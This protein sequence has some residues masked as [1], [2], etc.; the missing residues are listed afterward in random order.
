MWYLKLGSLFSGSGTWE[1]AASLCKINPV[2]S[3]EIEPFPIKVTNARFPNT[4]QLGDIT[5]INGAEIEPVDIITFSSPCQDLSIAGNRSGL[6]GEQS[7]LFME[8]IRIIREMRLATNNEY[9][10]FIIWENV[11]G[12]F[13]SNKGYDFRT[14]LEEIAETNIPIPKYGKWAN[15]GM[16]ELSNCQ[17]AWRVLDAQHWGVPQRRKRI[18]LI[19][20]FGGKCAREI[21]FK[22]EGLFGDIEKSGEKEKGTSKDIERSIRKTSGVGING[23]IAGTL[24]AKITYNISSTLNCMHEQ[25]YIATY[26]TNVIGL[27]RRAQSSTGYISKTLSASVGG[28]NIPCITYDARGNGDG[29]ICNTITGDHEN[30]ITDYT[31]LVIDNNITIPIHDKATRYK[32]GEKTRN[33]DGSANGLGIGQN[34]D[35]CPTLDT[36]GRHAIFSVNKSFENSQ[37]GNYREGIGTLRASGGDYGGGSENQIFTSTNKDN[38]Y[39]VRRLTPKECGRLQGFPDSWCDDIPHSD[40]AE[41]KMWGNGIALPCVLFIMR[42]VKSLPLGMGI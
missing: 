40:T 11:T 24:D 42:G 14:V 28:D 3:S 5:K 6:K 36:K 20:D 18:F 8:A 17:V 19:A 13:S 4:K 23:Q 25:P 31:A 27:D 34:G 16:V 22:P 35:P 2:W 21:L 29:K 7:S 30:R 39:I 10:R 41:Y 12:V 1:L 15:A 38:N 33:D 26:D 37:Y 32:G 9:P